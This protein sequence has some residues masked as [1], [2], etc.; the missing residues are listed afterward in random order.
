MKEEEAAHAATTIFPVLQGATADPRAKLAQTTRSPTSEL[1]SRQGPPPAPLTGMQQTL[2]SQKR[3]FRYEIMLVVLL[4][5]FLLTR[6]C[7]KHLKMS[8]QVREKAEHRRCLL[9]FCCQY[10]FMVQSTGPFLEA[11]AGIFSSQVIIFG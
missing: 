1:L 11:R 9:W 4:V 8:P 2:P 10:V 6:H 7:I 5:I 3:K